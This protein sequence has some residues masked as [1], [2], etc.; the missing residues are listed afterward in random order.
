MKIYKIALSIIAFAGLMSVSSC[1]DTLDVQTDGHISMSEVFKDR[2]RTMGF[3]NQCYTHRIN[4]Y[5]HNSAL[6]DEAYDNRV[7]EGGSLTNRWYERGMDLNTYTQFEPRDW[8]GQFQGIRFCC[9]FIDNAPNFTGYQTENELAGW[10]AQAHTLRAL[11]YLQL[12]TRYGKFPLYTHDITTSYWDY[13]KSDYI[14]IVRQ[15]LDDCDAAL[16]TNYNALNGFAWIIRDAENG[17]M[18]RAVAYAIKSR[19]AVYACSPLFQEEG[20][21]NMS[22]Q[23]AMD[24]CGEALAACLSPDGGYQLYSQTANGMSAYA[25]YFHL[26][27]WQN[28]VDKRDHETIYAVDESHPGVWNTCSFP[29]RSGQS[30]AYLNPTQELVD[31]YETTDGVPVI[32]GYSDAE[33]LHPIYNPENTT[34]RKNDP[35][36]NRDLRMAATIMYNGA[37]RNRAS[38]TSG[39]PLN[40]YDGAPDGIDQ[41][42]TINTHTGYYLRKYCDDNSTASNQGS[43]DGYMRVFRLAE[44]YLNYAE[45]AYH[46][47]SPDAKHTYSFTC[48]DGTTFSITLSAKDAVDIVRERSEMPPLPD[49]LSA[50]EFEKRYR[51]ERFV[52]FAFE[53]MRYYDIRRWKIMGD[54]FRQATGVHCTLDEDDGSFIYTRFAFSPRVATDDKYYFTPLTSNEVD[55][56]MNQTGVNWQNPGW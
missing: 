11:Y 32:L 29:S 12:M 49:G 6:T 10:T 23:E 47:G 52:E 56:I 30:H 5:L 8:A 18:T 24:I 46:A 15:I 22:W 41:T 1:N 28:V 19:A 35:Y 31:A 45:A 54:V 20:K 33:H 38:S 37:P 40:I 25:A 13:Q 2:Q 53:G 14:D 9:N 34:Y 39:N 50:S 44:L 42:T 55:K 27:P 48:Q 7:I 43:N 17:I 36:L 4:V 21:E 3:L 26:K 51:N 16:A